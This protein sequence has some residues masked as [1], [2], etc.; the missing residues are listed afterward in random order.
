MM[1]PREYS[2]QEINVRFG[3]LD[4]YERRCVVRFLQ[5]TEA[6]YAWLAE[7][8][9]H[10]GKQE[11]TP[12]DPDAIEASLYHAHLPKLA[13]LDS[14]EFDARSGM[15]RYDGDDLIDTLLDVT[16]ETHLPEA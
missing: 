4:H 16:P 7:M 9:S 1:A 8:V 15:A 3:L 13:A 5:E 10:L 2:T 14:F 11:S 6:G 12:D